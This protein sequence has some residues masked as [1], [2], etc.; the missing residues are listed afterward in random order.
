MMRFARSCAAV[1]GLLLSAGAGLAADG[2][3]AF[4]CSGLMEDRELRV[5]EGRDGMF[6]RVAHS[7]WMRRLFSDHAVEDFGRLARAL[8]QRG[9]T[10]IFAPVPTKSVVVPHLLP[11]AA[12]QLGYDVEIAK[13]VQSDILDR[14]GAFDVIAVDLTDAMARGG[15][16]QPAFFGADTHWNSAGAERAAQAIA[17]VIRAHPVYPDL[18]K[19]QFRTTYLRDEPLISAMR[20]IIQRRCTEK[21]PEVIAR[22]HETTIATP[23]TMAAA[24]AALDIGLEDAPLDI[25]LEDAPLDIGLEDAPLDIGLEDAPLDIGLED[26]PLNIGLEDAPLDIGLED[27]P[28]DIGLED[29]P[30]DIGLG[31]A[32]PARRSLPPLAQR[33]PAA[34]VG[35]SFSDMPQVNFTGFL[36]QHSS[37]EV[38]NYAVTGGGMYSAITAYLTSDDFQTSPPVFL[39]WEAPIYLN[40]SSEGDQQIRELIA[41]ASGTCTQPVPVQVQDGGARLLADLPAGLGARDTLFLDAGN[42]AVNTVQFR[43]ASPEGR[44]RTKSITRSERVRPNGRFYMPL[45]GLWSSG[46]RGVEITSDLPFGA[47]ARLYSCTDRDS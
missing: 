37:L 16:D 30:L 46:V 31:D 4:G 10:L 3:S 22:V 40:P 42:R 47:S 12:L 15:Q 14:L 13:R 45:S 20:R 9:T 8:E 32:Q 36:A 17:E 24:N 41:A 25:G 44:S 34:V 38:V 21:V 33:L 18:P 2:Q 28:L 35:T 11:E 39:V 7:L 29:A 43:F 5:V 27:A 6:F 26:A 19:T 23:R 1:I